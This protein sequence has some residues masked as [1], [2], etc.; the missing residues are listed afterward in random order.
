[1]TTRTAK[2]YWSAETSCVL[3]LQLHQEAPEVTEQ[4]LTDGTMTLQQASRY[5]KDGGCCL[6]HARFSAVFKT[7]QNWRLNVKSYSIAINSLRPHAMSAQM[8]NT[9]DPSM[10]FQP[11]LTTQG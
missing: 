11:L 3:A 7:T 1:M 5:Y 2:N 4:V 8:I 9:Q 10:P 6:D